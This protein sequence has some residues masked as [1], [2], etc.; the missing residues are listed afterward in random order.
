MSS[1]KTKLNDVAN[2][3]PEAQIP[4][5]RVGVKGVRLPVHVLDRENEYQDTIATV[6]MFVDLPAHFRG[7]HMSRFVEILY[8]YRDNINY[9]TMAYILKMMIERFDA[10]RAHIDIGFPYFVEKAAPAS[11]EKSFLEVRARFIGE[12][13]RE[14][15]FSL[16]VTVPVA[17]LCPC[18]KDISDAGAHNQRGDVYVEIES[19]HM[20]WIEEIVAWAEEAASAPL[21]AL[22]KREDEKAVT[23]LA[24]GRPR[25][26]EDVVR[27]LADRLERD[28]RVRS[29]RTECTNFESI[30]QHDAYATIARDKRE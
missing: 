14:Y 13:V 25:F 12:F 27:N 24:Y 20:I 30:H 15:K 7:T 28:G 4:I 18:S 17:N 21:F 10:A 5:D 11:G 26:V 1:K 3:R 6:D 23:E 22:L 16:G 9:R 2:E 8:R 19:R 29:Y